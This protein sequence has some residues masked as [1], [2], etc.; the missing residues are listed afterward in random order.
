[1]LHQCLVKQML[2]ITGQ[3]S[4]KTSPSVTYGTNDFFRKFEK[5]GNWSTITDQSRS[6]SNNFT[7]AW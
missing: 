5:D 6:N 4:I 2:R 7:L 3:W 1:M